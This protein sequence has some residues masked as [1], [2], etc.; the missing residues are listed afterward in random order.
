MATRHEVKVIG[1]GFGRTGTK[2]VKVALDSLGFGPCYHG[3]EIFTNRFHVDEWIDIANT[4]DKSQIDWNGKIFAN[5]NNASGKVYNSSMDWPAAHYYK[6]LHEYYPKAKFILTK[7]DPENW[8]KSMI[9]T[10]VPPPWRLTFDLGMFYRLNLFFNSFVRKFKKMDDK[11]YAQ[12]LFNGIYNFHDNKSMAINSFNKHIENVKQYIDEDRLF[13]IDW[14]R[15]DQDVMFQELCK[16]LEVE[17]KG[18][19][20]AKL[21][22]TKSMR[23]L[24]KQNIIKS[25]IKNLYVHGLICFAAI[26]LYFIWSS[27]SW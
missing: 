8:Y 4:T 12:E 26:T 19:T 3:T 10:F 15:K 18:Q 21:N 25:L 7:R 17:Y 27:W 6:Y 22:D 9:N 23:Q 11:C 14:R 16:F 5:P 1:V 24:M 13:I 2:T 20:F